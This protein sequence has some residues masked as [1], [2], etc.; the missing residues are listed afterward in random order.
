[1][2]DLIIFDKPESLL[3]IPDEFMD[4]GLTT[5]KP[6]EIHRV[7]FINW[8]GYTMCNVMINGQWHS[9]DFPANITIAEFL[10]DGSIGNAHRWRKG[11][12]YTNER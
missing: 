3:P 2:S 7:E 10:M 11:R 5:C 1:M 9:Q 12:F 4:R 6:D 8:K